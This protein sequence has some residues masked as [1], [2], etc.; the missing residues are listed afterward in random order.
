MTDD[1]ILALA[2]NDTF[3]RINRATGLVYSAATQINEGNDC[4]MTRWT[5]RRRVNELQILLEEMNDEHV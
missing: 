5:L 1:E 3:S 4:R 2:N